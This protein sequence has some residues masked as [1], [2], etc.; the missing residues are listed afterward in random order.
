M[1]GLSIFMILQILQLLVILLLFVVYD[2]EL[3][4]PAKNLGVY[5]QVFQAISVTL[6]NIHFQT[7]VLTCSPTNNEYNLQV[8]YSLTNIVSYLYFLNVVFLMV[9]YTIYLE[10]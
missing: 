5:I 4:I 1:L 2:S 3:G 6:L 10:A 8:P 9:S 7:F